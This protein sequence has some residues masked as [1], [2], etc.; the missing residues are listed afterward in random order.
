MNGKQMSEALGISEA[1]VSRLRRRG[2]PMDSA[3][4]AAA[5]R[6]R[7]MDPARMKG[8]RVDT[9]SQ[10]PAPRARVVSVEAELRRLV[11]GCPPLDPLP[12]ASVLELRQVLRRMSFDE[13][14]RIYADPQL[15]DVVWRAAPAALVAWDC[16]EPEGADDDWYEPIPD[17]DLPL[18]HLVVAGT[19]CFDFDAAGVPPQGPRPAF[20]DCVRLAEVV[21]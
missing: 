2:M 9:E 18:L 19:A 8:T 10:T 11:A 6:R 5:W 3:E 16:W 7:H 20:R 14:R 17:V 21:A 4:R 1:M 12:E 13:F 15:G